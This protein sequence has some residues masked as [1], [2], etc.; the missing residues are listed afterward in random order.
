[1]AFAMKDLHSL[2]QNE[3]S[4]VKMSNVKTIRLSALLVG[5]LIARTL[6]RHVQIM[7]IAWLACLDFSLSIVN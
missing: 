5:V 3:V 2:T 7:E 4:F 6:A 1:M